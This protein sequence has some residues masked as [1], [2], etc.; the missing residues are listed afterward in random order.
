[1]HPIAGRRALDAYRVAR[2]RRRRR[3]FW[4]ATTGLVVLALGGWALDSGHQRFGWGAAGSG[5]FLLVVVLLVGRSGDLD[6]WRRGAAGEMETARL[7]DRLPRRRW[8]V[9][10]DLRVPGSSAN[11]DHV[12]VGPTG[13]W[14]IDSKT[15]R[16][17]VRAGWGSV[18]FGDRRLDTGPTRWES[19]VVADRLS[20]VTGAPVDVRPLVA[21]H[22][23]GLRPRGGRAGGIR[24]VPASA[25]TRRLRRGRRQLSRAEVAQVTEAMEVA[26]VIGEQMGG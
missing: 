5:L 1:M 23:S 19:E 20:A 16:A 18:R 11:I 17:R 6:R 24:V 26:F 4:V 9:W 7:L 2:G 13:V 25:L 14:V 3:L 22:G 12:A 15:T 10:H 21:V 8:V